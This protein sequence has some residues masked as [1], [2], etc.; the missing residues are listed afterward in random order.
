MDNNIVRLCFGLTVLVATFDSQAMF[1]DDPLLTKIMSEFEYFQEHGNHA[2]EWDIDAWIGQDLSKYWI[3]S[4]GAYINSEFEDANIEFVYSQAI[5]PHWDSQFGVRHDFKAD[6][7]G[8]TRNWLSYGIIGTAPYF[9][10]V[11]ARVLVGQESSTQLLI[12]LQRELMITQEWVITPELD[13]VANGRT[14]QRFAEGSGLA[15]IEIGLRLGY[16][17]NANRKFQPF[18]G[19]TARQTFGSTRSLVKAQGN[20]SG[21]L[22]LV[23]GMHS[24]F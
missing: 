4:S 1:K 18:I 16:E 24:W 20:S 7:D 12:E 13:I 22:S 23:I 14:N 15:E 10:D 11:D 17:H 21:N 9:I 19:V 8:A 3:K 6:S 5:S 2:I